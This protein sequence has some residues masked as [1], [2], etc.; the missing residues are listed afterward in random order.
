MMRKRVAVAAVVGAVALVALVASAFGAT[1]SKL[2]LFQFNGV[3]QPGAAPGQVTIAVSGGNHRA[4]QRMLGR[5]LDQT[6]TVG[7]QTPILRWSQGVP[8]IVTAADLTPGDALTINVRAAQGSSLAQVESTPANIVSDRGVNPG[9]PSLPL[10][11][12]RGVVVGGPQAGLL[13]VHVQSGNVRAMRALIGN[14]HD[15]TFAFDASTV[16]L[17]WQG[18]LPTVIGP[19]DVRIG[20]PV[21]VRVRAPAGSTLAKVLGTPARHIGE[22]EPANPAAPPPAS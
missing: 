2:V 18:N 3:T 7:P 16:F 1:G 12:F 15:V 6:F 8:K 9:R 10:W 13:T 4:L 11:L 22:H 14:G 19:A 21:T 5:P 20:D 17:R